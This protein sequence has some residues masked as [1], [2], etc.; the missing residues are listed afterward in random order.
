MLLILRCFPNHLLK[1][2]SSYSRPGCLPV[3]FSSEP[4]C[5]LLACLYLGN[6]SAGKYPASLHLQVS[7]VFILVLCDLTLH[8]LGNVSPGVQFLLPLHADSRTDCVCWLAVSHS[9]VGPS[10][11]IST[12]VDSTD[13]QLLCVDMYLGQRI[14]YFQT[15][16]WNVA[17]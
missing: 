17:S 4:L 6:W 5:C 10:K 11:G 9:A 1:Q 14:V 7:C 3:D 12:H 13:C 16:E 15:K 2:I 8:F